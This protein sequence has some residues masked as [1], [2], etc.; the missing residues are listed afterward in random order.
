MGLKNKKKVTSEDIVSP[1]AVFV[2]DKSGAKVSKKNKPKKPKGH[3]VETIITPLGKPHGKKKRKAE[4]AE[5][6]VSPQKI[7]RMEKKGKIQPA[8]SPQKVGK[9][10]KNAKPKPSES[11]DDSDLSMSD[12]SNEEFPINDD[13]DEEESDTEEISE[14]IP[15]GK[16][17][18]KQNG[19]ADKGMKQQN[20]TE[21]G[22]K[23]VDPLDL[24]EAKITAD[25]DPDTQAKTME[26]ILE[27]D[28]RTLFVKGKFSKMSHEDILKL[29]PGA[30]DVRTRPSG[31]IA[32]IEF[33]SEKKTEKAH[34][35]LQKMEVEG[36]TLKVDYCGTKSQYKTPVKENRSVGEMKIR[37]Q[38][39]YVGG[40]PLSC[41]VKE[42]MKEFPGAL[43]ARMP[44][45]KRATISC[46][47]YV[48][49]KSTSDAKKA[50]LE[51]GGKVIGGKPVTVLFA[52]AVIKKEAPERKKK[53]KG[54]RKNKKPKEEE[55]DSE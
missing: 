51:S 21:E 12:D 27:R 30:C 25:S 13:S 16:K 18:K 19:S 38:V 55:A 6:A 31:N 48:I 52:K 53:R 28:T 11:S 5:L 2:A 1:P 23:R 35:A 32:Y 39:L 29:A 36:V 22:E 4:N 41:T 50:F 7:A 33:K 8:F 17:Q 24:P 15:L 37:P 9:K 46:Y 42:V 54:S 20:K 44:L 43:Q 14:K 49:F 40:L 45:T 26:R 10:V 47:A 3:E 34:A